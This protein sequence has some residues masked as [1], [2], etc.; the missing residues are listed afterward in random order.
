MSD[1]QQGIQ[2]RDPFDGWDGGFEPEAL[3]KD[4]D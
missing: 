3:N 2:G 1:R 4:A